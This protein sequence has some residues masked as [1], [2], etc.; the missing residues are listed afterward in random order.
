MVLP[1]WCTPARPLLLPRPSPSSL[2]LALRQS[3]GCV[4]RTLLRP[5]CQRRK[6]FVV[7]PGGFRLPVVYEALPLPLVDAIQLSYRGGTRCGR[8]YRRHSHLLY[9]ANAQRRFQRQLVGQRCMEEYCGREYG[10]F[11]DTR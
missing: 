9:R 5:T 6:L 8:H 4:D 1:D 7:G 11:E 2:V 3:P 10:A